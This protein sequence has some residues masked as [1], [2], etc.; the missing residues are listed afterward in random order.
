MGARSRRQPVETTRSA[1]SPPAARSAARVG[2]VFASMLA[3]T[4]LASIAVGVVGDR[5]GRRR[6]YV[7]LLALMGVTGAVY[8]V[9]DSIFVLVPVALIG[10]LSTDANES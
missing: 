1:S 7:L 10:T 6:A 3:G 8:A 2:L 4:A 5:V 9:A